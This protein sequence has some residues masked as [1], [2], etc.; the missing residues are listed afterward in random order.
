MLVLP[1][2]R[3]KKGRGEKGADRVERKLGIENV[4]GNW[5]VFLL[6]LPRSPRPLALADVGGTVSGRW[7]EAR[8][9]HLPLSIT[10]AGGSTR[11]GR[12]MPAGQEKRELRVE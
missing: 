2:E 8:G 5:R 10:A 7:A 1:E 11:L 3:L 9:E 4:P 12:P 6:R